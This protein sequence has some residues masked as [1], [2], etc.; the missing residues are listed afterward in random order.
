MVQIIWTE[1]IKMKEFEKKIS[2]NE[3]INNQER[4]NS[5]D[6]TERAKYKKY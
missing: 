5:A 4:E 6:E 1:S 2:D 3:D